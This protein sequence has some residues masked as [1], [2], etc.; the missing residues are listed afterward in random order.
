MVQQQAGPQVPADVDQLER[1]LVI[2]LA[3]ASWGHCWRGRSILFHCDNSAVVDIW[4]KGSTRQPHIRLLEEKFWCLAPHANTVPSPICHPRSHQL[5]PLRPMAFS[6]AC[7]SPVHQTN[8]HSRLQ[9]NKFGTLIKVKPTLLIPPERLQLFAAYLA[10][11]VS[12]KTIKVYIAGL[13]L[14]HILRGL[15]DPTQDPVLAYTIRG[16]KRQQGEQPRTR[17]P[18]TI[19]ILNMLKS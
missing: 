12:H 2:L 4:N 3:A 11:S 7:H 14:G 18:I 8:I 16:I 1:T 10:N 9:C 17:L 19:S 13:R 6:R 15:P 5:D